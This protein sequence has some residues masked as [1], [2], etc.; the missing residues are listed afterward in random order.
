[1]LGE[2]MIRFQE[3]C[4]CVYNENEKLARTEMCILVSICDVKVY[5]VD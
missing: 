5:S 1:M 2:K 3:L 4:V